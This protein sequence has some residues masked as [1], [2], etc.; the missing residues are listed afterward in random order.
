MATN[1]MEELLAQQR[2]AI[3]SRRQRAGR[4]RP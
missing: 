1:S 4:A 3:N 2:R